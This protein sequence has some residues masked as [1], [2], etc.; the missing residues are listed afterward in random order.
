VEFDQQ[1]IR[2]EAAQMNRAS[3]MGQLVASLAHELAQPL[4]AVLSNAQAASRLALNNPIDMDEI[5]SALAD[6]IEDDQRACSIL[7]HVRSILRKHTVVPHR[8]NLNEIV[9]EVG[10][11]VKSTAHLRG[12]TL[13]S[14]L[15]PDAIFVIG[16]EIPLQQVLLNLVINAMDA[17]AQM[18]VERRVLT[19]KTFLKAENASGLLVVEDQGPG[20]PE[21]LQA[22]LFAPFFTTKKDGLGMGLAI[23]STILAS[24]GG[25]INFENRPERGATFLVELPLGLSKSEVLYSTDDK[26][27]P[28]AKEVSRT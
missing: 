12:I 18:P 26:L 24:L 10:L 17:M 20:I 1:K 14:V 6:I 15:S 13:E 5:R 9:E 25:S 19:V 21:E 27:Y 28:V 22:K 16:D 7:N 8:V 4:A 23:C 3:E 11:L 2:E